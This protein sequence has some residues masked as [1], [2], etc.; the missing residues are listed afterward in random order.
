MYSKARIGSHPIHPMLI[1]FPAAF[2]TATVATLLAYF[3]TSDLFYYRAALVASC[4]G[5]VM[6]L[7]AAIPGSIDLFS[8]PRGSRAW[9]TGIK[10]ASFALLAT[11]LFAVTAALLWR[12]WQAHVD[13]A[14]YASDA[15]L[16]LAIALAGLLVL[17]IVGSLGWSLVQTHHV[18]VKPAFLR[19][20]RLA[21]RSREVDADDFDDLVTPLPRTPDPSVPAYRH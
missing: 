2:Y 19:M 20:D 14:V 9:N 7:V 8:L 11:G 17:V 4:A 12:D 5:V 15:Y 3:A 21:D 1:V 10:H 16:P 6:A 18:G 13:R